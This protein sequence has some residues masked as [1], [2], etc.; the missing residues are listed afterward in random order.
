MVADPVGGNTY[1]K[2]FM[3]GFAETME[4]VVYQT[5]QGEEKV[6]SDWHIYVNRA[7]KSISNLSNSYFATYLV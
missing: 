2:N 6:C 5:C 4:I 1:F 7:S 3:N